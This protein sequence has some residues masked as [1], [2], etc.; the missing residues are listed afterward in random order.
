MA[1]LEFYDAHN[2]LQDERLKPNWS[3]IWA[4]AQSEP[5]VGMVVNG[6]RES[7]W[8]EVLNL[9]QQH[10]V[11]I[12]S[13][14]YHP[15]YVKERTPQWR[16]NLIDFLDRIPS[17]IGEIGLDRWVKDYDFLAQEEVFT[18]QLRLAAERDLPVSIHCLK[19][20]GRMLEILQAEPLPRRGFLLHSFGGPVEMIPLL[21]KLGAYFSLSG[22]FAHARKERQRTAFRQIPRDRLLIETDAPDQLPPPELILHPL[23]DA[24]GKPI[25][26]PAN[27]L[28][29]YNFAAQLLE[30]PVDELT[31][32]VA[33]NFKRLFQPAPR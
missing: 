27:L 22:Y 18:W 14:G 31:A 15:W 11:I 3:A 24:Q 7:D 13:F 9:A 21:I 2:H 33:E 29:I 19:A 12:P 25:N 16:E 4:D 10:P 20:W 28:G 1:K 8:Q 32:Q 17:A 23:D 26:H 5:I 30:T 6:S